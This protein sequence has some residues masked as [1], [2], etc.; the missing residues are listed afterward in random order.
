MLPVALLRIG[1]GRPVR[2]LRCAGS[3]AVGFMAGNLQGR[4]KAHRTHSSTAITLLR[5]KKGGDRFG[6]LFGMPSSLLV[7]CD[8]CCAV[9]VGN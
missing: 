7:D 4:P 3:D 2:P 1:R 6:T 8:C 5:Q 9:G